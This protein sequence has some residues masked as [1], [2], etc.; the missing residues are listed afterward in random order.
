[1]PNSFPNG[2]SYRVSRSTATGRI[3]ISF[4]GPTPTEE[5]PLFLDEIS[6]LMPDSD[7]D[8]IWDLRELEGHNHETKDPIRK[9]L[10]AHKAR[11]RSVRVVIP[12]ANSLIKMVTAAM[13]LAVGMDLRIVEGIEEDE[14][15]RTAAG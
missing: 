1:M 3:I 2:R 8:L 12:R 14:R 13:G 5:V 9:W 4:R 10:K 15:P 11:I 7:A 6:E